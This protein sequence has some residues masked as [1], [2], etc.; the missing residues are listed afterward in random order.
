MSSKIATEFIIGLYL[1]YPSDK[2]L[3]SISLTKYSLENLSLFLKQFNLSSTE[4]I[5]DV[6]DQVATVFLYNKNS[7]SYD[8]VCNNYPLVPTASITRVDKLNYMYDIINHG[9]QGHKKPL[10]RKIHNTIYVADHWLPEYV[11]HYK[12]I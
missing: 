9:K 2:Y 1:Q 5:I 12:A 7:K 11:Y 6:F 3:N 8:R 4:F 10:E